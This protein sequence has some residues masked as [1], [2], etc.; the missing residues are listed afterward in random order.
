MC[1]RI[2]KKKQYDVT[3]EKDN[4]KKKYNENKTIKNIMI[5]LTRRI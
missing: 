4:N 1:I 2:N 5:L 3:K